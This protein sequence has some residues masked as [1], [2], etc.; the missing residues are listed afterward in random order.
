MFVPEVEVGIV[1]PLASSAFSGVRVLLE[2]V[3][4]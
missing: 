1:T 4:K 3:E 2:A